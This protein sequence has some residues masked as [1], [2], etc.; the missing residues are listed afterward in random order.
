M[1][2]I[3]YK[4][5]VISAV[6]VLF[7]GACTVEPTD[8]A[9]LTTPTDQVEEKMFGHCSILMHSIFLFGKFGV[10]CYMAPGW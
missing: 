5:I 7:V 4:A 2:T 3:H 10:P 9:I 1:G 8:Q 6:T